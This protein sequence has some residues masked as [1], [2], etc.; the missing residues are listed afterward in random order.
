MG[1]VLDPLGDKLL[2]GSLVLSLSYVGLFPGTP[3]PFVNVPNVSSV[4]LTGLILARDAGLLASGLV[5]RYRSLPRPFSWKDYFDPSIPS[6]RVIPTMIS[7]VNTVLQL[8]LVG[9]TLLVPLADVPIDWPPLQCLQWTVAG[10]TL[11]SGLSYI[12]H[13]RQ[14]IQFLHPRIK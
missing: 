11:W 14:V 1:S 12:G 9:L 13:H 10:T 3:L 5:I 6:A 8:A 7:K 4:P 2:V